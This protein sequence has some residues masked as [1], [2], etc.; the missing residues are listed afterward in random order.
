MNPK[1]VKLSVRKHKSGLLTV[2]LIHKPTG[3]TVET[4]GT[5]YEEIR[6]EAEMA[7]EA[8]VQIEEEAAALRRVPNVV[9]RVS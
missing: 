3:I 9:G 4:E 2:T 7:L 1:H 5:S 6:L 8:E